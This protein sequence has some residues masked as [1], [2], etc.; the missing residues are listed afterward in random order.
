[1][2]S[3]RPLVGVHAEIDV[4][5]RRAARRGECARERLH[6]GVAKLVA[7]DPDLLEGREAAGAQS[8]TEGG[9][10]LIADVVESEVDASDSR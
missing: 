5:D 4:L 3:Y 8:G 1:M 2:V 10:G 6:T 7:V 9:H